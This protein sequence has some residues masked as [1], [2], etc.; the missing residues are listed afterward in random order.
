MASAAVPGTANVFGNQPVL[1]QQADARRGFTEKNA[2]LVT[3]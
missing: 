2:K 3:E 1:V